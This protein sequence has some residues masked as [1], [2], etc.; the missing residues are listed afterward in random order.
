MGYLGTRIAE[1]T[2][3]SQ[4]ERIA[5]GLAYERHG[6]SGTRFEPSSITLMSVLR[7]VLKSQAPA[8]G[9]VRAMLLG[10]GV[11]VDAWAT[12]STPSTP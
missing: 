8:Q 2:L 11:D 9:A 1:R 5:Q 6:I 10:L 3:G 12:D 4:L 7:S